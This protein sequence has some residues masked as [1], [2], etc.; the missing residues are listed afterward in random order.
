LFMFRLFRGK[1]FFDK[2]FLVFGA[3]E[4]NNQRKLFSV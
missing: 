2:Y 1:I 3:I 4:N